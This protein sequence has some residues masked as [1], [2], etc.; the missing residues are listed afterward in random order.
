MSVPSLQDNTVQPTASAVS[1]NQIPMPA[2][3]DTT[4]SSAGN[5]PNPIPANTPASLGVTPAPAATPTG[6]PKQAPAQTAPSPAAQAPSTPQDLH[7]S[8]FK[9][10]LGTLAGGN[11]RAQRDAQG[12]PVTDANGQVQMRPASIKTLGASI[13]AGALSSMVAGMATPD[14]RTDLGGGRS[15]ADYSGAAAAGAQASQKFTQTGSQAEAQSQANAATAANYAATDHN[16]KMHAA[17]LGNLKLQGDIMNQGV[18]EDS[19]LIEAMK[20]NPTATGPDGKEL[21]TIKGEHVSETA[22]QK[23]MADGAAHVTRDS[24]LRDGVSNVYDNDGKQ[25]FNP[26]GTPRVEYTYTVYDHNASV[27]MTDEMKKNN[28]ALQYVAAGTAVPMAVLAKGNREKMDMQNAQGFVNQWSQQMH[29]F[30]DSKPAKVDFAAAVKKDAYLRKLAPQLGRY[31][32]MEPDQTLNQMQKD[33]VDD[34]LIG[35]FSNLLG[36][37]DREG[38]N[39][40]RA[41]DMKKQLLAD[42]DYDL[43]RAI[44]D[45]QSDVP[46]IHQ[47]GTKWLATYAAIQSTIAGGKTAAETKAKDT[48]TSDFAAFNSPDALGFQPTADKFAGNEKDAIK[49]YNKVL[50]PFKKNADDLSKMEG[51]YQQFSSIL[52]D[53]NN[54]KDLTGAQS[55][56]ALFNAIGISAE[57]LAG[58]G[59]RINSNT[60]EEHRDALSMPDNLVKKGVALFKNGEVV[61]PQQIRDYADIAMQTRQSKYTNLVNQAH[62]QSLN[63]DFVLPTGNGQKI[64]AATAKIFIQLAGGNAAKARAAA[65]AKG[66]NF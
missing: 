63:A 1:D 11:L 45:S 22:L 14:R 59:F 55:V 5:V 61:T 12:N 29:E 43:N 57:P 53:I 44:T 40:Q 52:S 21:S 6:T 38:M 37:V 50:T 23:M 64:D 10:I 47:K 26:D 65:T 66:W 31:A 19:P 39:K 49:Q 25:I 13:L 34:T 4:A 60:I 28:P 36:G 54:G 7:T 48:G 41:E 24:V 15:I 3:P 56:V 16:L 51:T 42:K 17:V 35:K 46:T 58:K 8:I 2:A 9:N 33:G 32:G 20:L 18:Q 27:A 62:N 30:D